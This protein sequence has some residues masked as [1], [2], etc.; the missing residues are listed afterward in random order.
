MGNSY[1]FDDW[2]DIYDR[3]YADWDHDLGFY[4]QHAVTSGGPVLELGCGTGRV[5]L[6]IAE[7]G[8][9]VTAI[10][11]SPR[12]LEVARRKAVGRGLEKSCLF[13]HGD[14]R[15]FKLEQQFPL[16]VIPFRS[17]QSL[18]TIEDQR[19]ALMAAKMHLLPSG[20]L[21]FDVF[22]PDI[23]MLANSDEDFFHIQ[24]VFDPLSNNS[25]AVWGKNNFNHVEQTNQVSLFIDEVDPRGEILNRLHRD[26]TIRYAFRYEMQ[27]LL[28]SSGFIVEAVYGD[29]AQGPITEH[30]DDMVWITKV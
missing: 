4:L 13:Y 3:V 11:L 8:I 5:S 23:Q 28:E 29:F 6:A 10:D 30:S 17:F 14:M 26:W 18:L 21:I 1:P 16:I 9:P 12:M 20:K 27:L 2:A 22:A 24:D 25:L 19:S 15:S 7:L